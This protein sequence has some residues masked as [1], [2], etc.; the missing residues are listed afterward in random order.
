MALM[1]VNLFILKIF[2][3]VRKHFTLF[4]QVLF[5]TVELFLIIMSKSW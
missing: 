5:A 4:Y 1:E 3:C 2:G